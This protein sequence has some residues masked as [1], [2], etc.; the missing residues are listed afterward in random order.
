VQAEKSGNHVLTALLWSRSVSYLSTRFSLWRAWNGP[1]VCD[2][3]WGFPSPGTGP[4]H[5]CSV[6]MITFRISRAGVS[7]EVRRNDRLLCYF[8]S[9]PIARATVQGYMVQIQAHGR[10]ATLVADDEVFAVAAE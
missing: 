8:S 9:F 1:A 6:G 4:E 3:R 5:L 2:G 7:W 10:S